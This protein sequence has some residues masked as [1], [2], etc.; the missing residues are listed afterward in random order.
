M[1]AVALT[2]VAFVG[3]LNDS[4]GAALYSVSIMAA[5]LLPSVAVVSSIAEVVIRSRWLS[6]V[7]VVLAGLVGTG[8]LGVYAA[9]TTWTP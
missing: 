4:A 7:A 1:C 6:T 9:V 5:F 8:V 2:F 3:S